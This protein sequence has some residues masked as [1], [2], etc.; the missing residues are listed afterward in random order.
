MTTT[1]E[2][3]DR[4]EITDLFARLSR[5]LDSGNFDDIRTVY[6]ADVTVRSP[7]A[8][9]HGLDEVLAYLRKSQVDGEHAQHLHGDVLVTLDG[10]RAEASA[11]QLV[12]Y[13]RTGQ[14]AHLQSG[15]TT[16]FTAV[17]TPAGWRVQESRISLA[18]TR[19]L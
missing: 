19:E 18:W 9:L 13:Y 14:P 7:R 3:A 2:L 12:S 8:E 1:A 11:N 17:R 16:G 15:L 5:V 10:D 4:A 6:A